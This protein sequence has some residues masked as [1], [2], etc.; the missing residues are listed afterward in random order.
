MDELL[1]R[2]DSDMGFMH[3]PNQKTEIDT[4]HLQ[5]DDANAN[6]RPTQL[7]PYHPNE[8]ESLG[9]FGQ[10]T[11]SG[12]NQV[13]NL[14]VQQNNLPTGSNN[15]TSNNDMVEDD[16]TH[17]GDQ[18]IDTLSSR[19]SVIE[20]SMLNMT[21]GMNNLINFMKDNALAG[22]QQVAVSQDS[23][24]DV[25]TKTKK[26]QRKKSSHS[27]RPTARSSAGS[28]KSKSNGSQPAGS[29][30]DPAGGL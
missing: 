8:D 1:E 3:D 10:G 7:F 30:E 9:T 11:V 13:T 29:V 27:K 12:G 19:M 23:K 18:T 22:S 2:T 24:N 17:D 16:L 28:A 26:S 15:H 21:Q 20:A 4:S 5:T 6:L 25:K 14:A